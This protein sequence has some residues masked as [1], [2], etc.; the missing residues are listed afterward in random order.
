MDL[1]G[2]AT[3]VIAMEDASDDSFW[4]RYFWT[5]S[6]SAFA[7]LSAACVAME[8]L[9]SP[10]CDDGDDGDDCP[11]CTPALFF[12]SVNSVLAVCATRMEDPGSFVLLLALQV[13]RDYTRPRSIKKLLEARDF[14]KLLAGRR[15][16]G[17]RPR[18][19]QL[20]ATGWSR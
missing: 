15:R 7:L 16:R 12:L 8:L 1:Q 4:W 9:L 20:V 17:H 2:A 13:E 5:L 10:D 3:I 14:V 19:P 11:S 18:L 6:W